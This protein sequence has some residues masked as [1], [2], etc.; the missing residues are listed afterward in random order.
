MNSG[1][2]GIIMMLVMIPVALQ[3]MAQETEAD[4]SSTGLTVNESRQAEPQPQ[5][6]QSR[7]Y[8]GGHLNLSFGKYTVVGAQPII[9]YKI[10]PKLSAGIKIR[11]D[12]IKDKRYSP[13]YTTSNYGGSLFTRYRIIPALYVHAEYAYNNYEINYFSEGSSRVWV[14]YLLLGAGYSQRVGSNTWLNFQVLFDVL[15]NSNS[16]Y[17]SWQPFY[18][19]G[20]GVGF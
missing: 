7:I 9:G 14:P 15:Q 2:T 4:T 11:Y 20:V 3:T 13:D 19:V 5:P 17:K 1:F 18:S 12:Y 16:P 6:K 10:T 8:F